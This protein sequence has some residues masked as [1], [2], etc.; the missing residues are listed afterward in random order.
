MKKRITFFCKKVHTDQGEIRPAVVHCISGEPLEV[1]W[2]EDC[3]D[4]IRLGDSVHIALG[5]ADPHVHF[6]E[7]ILPSESEYESDKG[8]LQG[9]VDCVDAVKKAN[10]SYS[11]QAGVRSALKGGVVVVGAMGNVPWSPMNRQR[12]NQMRK[13]Y[14]RKSLIPIVVWPRMEPNQK[15]ISG[16]E[17]KDFGSTFGGNGITTQQRYDMYDEWKGEA[18]SFH[19][20]QAR[21]DQDFQNFCQK[22]FESDFLKHHFYYDENTVLACQKETLKIAE[23]TG[24]KSLLARHIPTGSGL[25]M[26]ADAQTSQL[27]TP[28]E[29]GLDYMYWSLERLKKQPLEIARINYRRPAFPK[30]EEQYSLITLTRDLV[31]QGR[32]IFF[33]SDHA[34]HSIRA[35]S[36]QKGMS[37]AP[38]TRNLEHTLQ[39]LMELKN[40]WDYQFRDL[41]LLSA[42]NPIKHL[43]QYHD[44]PYP[45]GTL[46]EG[47]MANLCIFDPEVSYC[48]DESFLKIQLDDPHYHT[49]LKGETLQGQV[50]FTVVNGRVFD[51]RKEIKLLN[52]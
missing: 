30:K 7:S 33:G 29:V 48:V 34:P 6:R 32:Q 25:Q 2:N 45:V 28:L 27:K 4:A 35:K 39:Y 43:A 23:L 24:V 21:K 20:D 18:V 36:F 3:Q 49:A 1:G 47:A 52:R 50:L 26:M 13:M 16:Q 19:N 12:W 11:V 8:S 31:R 41:D 9:Y 15:K 14:Q 5:K 22:S 51:V 38:G 37:G 40:S 44:F 42:I 46:S 17:G 10:A